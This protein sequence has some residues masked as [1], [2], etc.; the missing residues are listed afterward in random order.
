MS[1]DKF[2][3]IAVAA[4][5]VAAIL[6]FGNAAVFFEKRGLQRKAECELSAA[7]GKEWICSYQE[8]SGIGAVISSVAWPLYWSYRIAE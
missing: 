4:Y 8:A 2:T 7:D 6:T 5:L 1:K 3:K